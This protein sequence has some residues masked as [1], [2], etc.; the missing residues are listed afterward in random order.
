MNLNSA[1]FTAPNQS[2]EISIL[3]TEILHV[4][5]NKMNIQIIGF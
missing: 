2:S 1:D 5:Q 4:F 3:K